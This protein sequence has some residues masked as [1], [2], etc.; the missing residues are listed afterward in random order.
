[1]SVR[2]FRFLHCGDLHIEQPISGLHETPDHLRDAFLDAPLDSAAKVFQT[3]VSED[4]DFV[5]LAGDIVQPQFAGPR[6]LHFLIERFRD[7]AARGVPVYWVGGEADPPE[8][9]PSGLE[10]PGNVKFFPRHRVDECVV[11]IDGAPLARIIGSSAGAHRAIRYNDFHPD[12]NGLYTIAL[13]YGEG[14]VSAMQGRGLNYWALGCRHA[15]CTLATQ[16]QTIHYPGTPQARWPE[17]VGVHG[18]TVAY[19]DERKQTRISLIPCDVARFSAERVIIDASIDQE[20]LLNRLRDRVRRLVESSPQ[21]QWLVEWTIAGEGKLLTEMRRGDLASALLDELRQEFGYSQPAVW[22]VSLTPEDAA[23]FP[24]P[25]YEQDS[26]RG[27]FLRL[28]RQWQM[29]PDEPLGVENYVAE[30]HQSGLL[31]PAAVEMDRSSRDAAL[32]EASLLGVE[33]LGGGNDDE[34]ESQDKEVAS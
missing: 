16:P 14:D 34:N 21:T 19:V 5:L 4:V 3:A 29:N 30:T 13:T 11:E 24:P 18:C 17:E 31:G 27:D 6:G 28:I 12:Q 15:R 9:W 2:P 26:I 8:S 25:W 1:M 20:G 7:L 10:L 32:R 33:L 23:V 22:S